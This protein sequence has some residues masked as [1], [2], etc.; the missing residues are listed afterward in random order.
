MPK[1]WMAAPEKAA[2][3]GFTGYDSDERRNQ[4]VYVRNLALED[5]K[6]K[7]Q[8]GTCKQGSVTLSYLPGWDSIVYRIDYQLLVYVPDP[9][10]KIFDDRCA[11]LFSECHYEG[12]SFT[13]CDQ[14]QDLPEQGWAKPIKSFRLPPGKSVQ[15]YSQENL[16]GKLVTF[17]QSVDCLADLHFSFLQIS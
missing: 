1:E 16:K 15:M 12:D 11:E 5:G 9:A 8:L 3:A 2:L 14:I 4:R 13:L 10:L 6:A 7:V 17:D